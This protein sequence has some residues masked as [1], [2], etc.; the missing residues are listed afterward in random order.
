MTN[1]ILD[2]KT[3][4]DRAYYKFHREYINSYNR[5]YYFLNKYIDNKRDDR[6]QQPY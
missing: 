3:K 4:Y 1:Q 2:R 6:C 5:L